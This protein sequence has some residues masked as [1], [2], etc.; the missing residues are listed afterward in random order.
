VAC[1]I[2]HEI[3]DFAELYLACEMFVLSYE[4]WARGL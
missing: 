4:V 1:G 2:C 3:R